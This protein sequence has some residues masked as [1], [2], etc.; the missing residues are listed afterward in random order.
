MYIKIVNSHIFYVD[1]HGWPEAQCRFPDWINHDTW[2]DLSGQFRVEVDTKTYSKLTI[3]Y[4]KRTNAREQAKS[5]LRCIE[6]V[7]QDNTEKTFIGVSF[8]SVGCTSQ[9]QCVMITQKDHDVI[10]IK[11]G[12]L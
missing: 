5:K 4:K 7:S 2:R 12:E 6:E 9:Y 10:E 11:L 3:Y 8:T 1:A